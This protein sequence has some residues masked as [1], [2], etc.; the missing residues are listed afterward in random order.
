MM[1]LG[2]GLDP[3]ELPWLLTKRTTGLGGVTQW[4]SQCDSVIMYEALSLVPSSDLA[5]K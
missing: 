3:M 2:I 4:Q 5:I 1:L